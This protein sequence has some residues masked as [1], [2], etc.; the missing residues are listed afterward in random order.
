M[1]AK[2]VPKLWMLSEKVRIF[3]KTKWAKSE[4]AKS[5]WVKSEFPQ[6]TVS[7]MELFFPLCCKML[8]SPCLHPTCWMLSAVKKECSVTN[9]VHDEKRTRCFNLTRLLSH[10]GERP[11]GSGASYFTWYSA[12]RK[13]VWRLHRTVMREICK[14][15]FVHEIDCKQAGNANSDVLYDDNDCTL[16]IKLNGTSVVPTSCSSVGISSVWK[17]FICSVFIFKR[18]VPKGVTTRLV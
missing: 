12:W 11:L 14:Q 17:T 18:V 6:I 10:S 3:D 4:W 9:F 16:F 7:S 5:E 13:V 1:C 2:W 8:N 15:P